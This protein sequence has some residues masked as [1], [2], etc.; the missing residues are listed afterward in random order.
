MVNKAE[1]SLNVLE[2]TYPS[3]HTYHV[4]PHLLGAFMLYCNV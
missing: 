3:L 1:P 4:N 2:N